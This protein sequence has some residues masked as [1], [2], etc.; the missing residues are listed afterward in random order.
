MFTRKQ[1]RGIAV[2]TLFIFTCF[3]L[4]LDYSYSQEENPLLKAQGLYKQGNFIDA[5][6]VLEAFIGKIKGNPSEKKRLA[7]ANL[8]LARIYYEAGEDARVADYLKQAVE[9]YADIGKE[10]GNLDFKARLELVREARL[11]SQAAKKETTPAVTKETAKTEAAQPNVQEKEKPAPQ[12]KKK[13][14]FPL[15]LVILGVG[16]VVVLVVLLTKKKKQTLTVNLG[17]GTTGSPPGGTHSYKKDEMV[18]YNYAKQTGY[19][20]LTVKLD[21]AAVAASGAITM[22]RNHTLEVTAVKIGTITSVTVKYDL[23]FAGSN[24]K[25][26]QNVKVNGVDKINETFN[27]NV[28]ASDKYEDM[29]KIARSFI[30]TQPL[31]SILIRQE[32][33]SSYSF[34]Y[35]KED[36]WIWSTTYW[37]SVSSY[38]YDNGAD[39]GAPILSEPLFYL[40]VAPWAPR[41]DFA[42][43]QEKTII[44]NAPSQQGAPQNNSSSKAKGIS[45]KK[46]E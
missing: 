23:I 24:L 43:V 8:L 45:T 3:T 46:I 5:V 41:G 31:G 34:Y 2:F 28:H 20:Q 10:E 15:L 37:L 35:S 16:V 14:K 32:A 42:R 36:L 30:V 40:D 29:K 26:T 33:N 1:F 39:P 12:I 22:D 25:T 18:A 44:V 4:T 17:T 38:T 21:G 13:K 11:K 7:E 19:S 27:F 9:A 6:K